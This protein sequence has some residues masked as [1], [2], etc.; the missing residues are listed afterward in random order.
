METTAIKKSANAPKNA[1]KAEEQEPISN[2][3]E[4][5]EVSNVEH[6]LGLK[7]DDT[8]TYTFKIID[9][10][11][12]KSRHY[13]IGNRSEVYDGTRRR[14]MRYVPYMD[15]IWLDEQDP[16][17][18][19]TDSDHS[20]NFHM[21]ILR[22]DGKNKNLI[23]FLMKHDRFKG[24]KQPISGRG[25]IFDIDDPEFEAKKQL[26]ANEKMR[27]AIVAALSAKDEDSR[28]YFYILFGRQEDNISTIKSAVAD[29]A[30]KHP[31]SFLEIIADPRT[32]RKYLIK[33]GLDEGKIKIKHSMLKWGMSDSDILQLDPTLEPI[34]FIT[35]WSLSEAGKDF[36][37]LLKRQ[38]EK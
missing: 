21:G 35:N 37:E 14:V 22:V 11:A 12:K 30:K 29:Y 19:V 15:S 38:L 18:E 31:A 9:P 25:P 26:A 32:R 6:D 7:I 4:S 28:V 3:N 27:D 10:K 13:G 20:V 34:S 23:S 5:Q 2:V 36:V 8:K 24:N 16:S 17:A 33:K 1:P